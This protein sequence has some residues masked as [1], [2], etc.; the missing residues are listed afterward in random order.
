MECHTGFVAIAHGK[1]IGLELSK[2]EIF[3][4]EK[5]EVDDFCWGIIICE[6]LCN[7]PTL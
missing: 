5:W 4:R 2:I 3:Y 7:P 1:V 6:L